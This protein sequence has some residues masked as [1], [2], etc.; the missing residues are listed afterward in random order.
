MTGKEFFNTKFEPGLHVKVG[1]NIFNVVGVNYEEK[2][3]LVHFY[4]TI[5]IPYQDAEIIDTEELRSD[6]QKD[7]SDIINE[8]RKVIKKLNEI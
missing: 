1:N 3:V 8:M 7:I 5:S 6:E 2:N 4:G